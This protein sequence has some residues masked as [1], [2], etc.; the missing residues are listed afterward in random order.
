ME[1]RRPLLVVAGAALSVLAA[2]PGALSSAGPDTP[3]PVQV[4]VLEAGFAAARVGQPGSTST[5]ATATSYDGR[6]RSFVLHVPDGLLAPAPLVVALHAHSHG[7]DNLRAVARFEALADREGFVVAFPGGAGGSWNSGLCCDPGARE[8]VDDVAFLDQVIA[9]ARKKASID[10]G[11]ISLTGDSNGAMM[12]L[13]YACER[14]DVV[15][16]VAVVGG[17]LV[18]PCAPARPVAVLALLGAQDTV[19]P[20]AGGRNDNLDVTF[21]PLDASLQ[22]FRDAGGAVEL[23]V[24]A[25]TGHTWM[26]GDLHG[27]D[28]TRTVWEWLRDHPQPA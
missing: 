2:V 25:G 13:R 6:A 9:L 24:V 26:T 15:A 28:A 19:V 21:P 23:Q 1:L 14:A 20:L 3:P 4:T 8:Q 7:P 17:P 12:A 5:L 16:A 10:P 18:A 22:P 11:R 27:V